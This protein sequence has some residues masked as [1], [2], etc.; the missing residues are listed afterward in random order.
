MKFMS[1][2][3]AGTSGATTLFLF[4]CGGSQP[5]I[6]APGAMPRRPLEK[7]ISCVLGILLLAGC[8]ATQTSHDAKQVGPAQFRNYTFHPSPS[9]PPWPSFSVDE[10]RTFH[11]V[12]LSGGELSL[13]R[14]TLSLV[15][16]CQ[17]PFLRFAFPS[18]GGTEFPLVLFFQGSAPFEAIHA[19]WTNN[20]FYDPHDGR[21]LP[22]SGDNPKWNGIQF[23][24]D[25][26]GCDG[27]YHW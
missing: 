13:I 10:Y 25:H 24:V 20:M 4:G 2:R 27:E 14:K 21:I 9:P 23:E 8:A 19:L 7:R 18:D 3:A 15:K 6:G 5:P 1:F 22:M 12:T 16:P 11:K 17:R 26:T